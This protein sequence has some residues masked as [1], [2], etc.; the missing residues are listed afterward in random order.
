[1][2]IKCTVEQSLIESSTRNLHILEAN[3]VT[4][5]DDTK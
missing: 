3:F 1:M 5:R 2:H 4:Y